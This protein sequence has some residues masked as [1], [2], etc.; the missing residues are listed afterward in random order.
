MMWSRRLLFGI[1]CLLAIGMD[2][3]G[4]GRVVAAGAPAPT[5]G[6]HRNPVF[7]GPVRTGDFNGDGIADL[8]GSTAD[9]ANP[10]GPRVVTVAFGKSDGSLGPLMRTTTH[11]TVLAVGD[12]NA[13]GKLDLVVSRDRHRRRPARHRR[14]ARQRRRDV[15]HRRP[16]VVTNTNVYFALIADFDGDGHA[17]VAVGFD[18]DGGQSV[19]I[20]RGHGDFTFTV[21]T[22]RRGDSPIAGVVADLNGDGKP[23]LVDRER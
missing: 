6:I 16:P 5:V 3:F 10:S 7:I 19:M 4:R 22:S 9:P 23:D 12:L 8:A 13:D 1:V 11:G 2:G 17:D 18:D 21:G 14:A 20:E 15:R